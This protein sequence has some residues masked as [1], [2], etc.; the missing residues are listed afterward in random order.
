[1]DR[2]AWLKER[3]EAV[4]AQYDE[5]APGYD[6]AGGVY[7]VPIHASF[8][9]RLL[10]TCPAGGRV[11]DAPCGTGKWFAQVAASGRRVVGA[12]QSAG[13]LAQAR[14]KG[15]AESLVHVGL[16]ELPFDAEFDGVMTIDAME[17]VP[18]EDW[19]RVVANLRRA[20][21][22][23]GHLYMTVEELNDHDIEE[24]FEQQTARGL[25][26]VRGEVVEG[27]TAGYHYYPGRERVAGW[28]GEAGFE[29][30]AE[31]VDE[32]DGWGYRHVL[33]RHG[34]A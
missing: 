25:P 29:I 7:P 11:L 24:A 12:D 19:P 31:D 26:S 14:A 3:R 16:Q 13:M 30:V 10:A 1:M 27:D 20:L 23:G 32:Q 8:V 17:N 22:P 2:N 5:E 33:A 15:V 18:P 21:R 4:E 9:D 34:N 28:L 6:G